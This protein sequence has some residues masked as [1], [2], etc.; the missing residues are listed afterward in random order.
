MEEMGGGW[1][2]PKLL[3]GPRGTGSDCSLWL[4]SKNISSTCQEVGR[5]R[6]QAQGPRLW[7]CH[8]GGWWGE[9]RLMHKSP[10]HKDFLSFFPFLSLVCVL[11]R[12][13]FI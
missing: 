3:A 6:G 4:S 13:T 9:T 2:G 12:L 11:L 1:G 10:G 5:E 8:S 7:G